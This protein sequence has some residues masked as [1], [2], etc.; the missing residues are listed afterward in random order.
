MARRI[1]HLEAHEFIPAVGERH[2]V[3]VSRSAQIEDDGRQ[4]IAEVYVLAPPEAVA[5]H[6]HSATKHGILRVQVDQR[7]ALLRGEHALD[8][9]CAPCIQITLDAPPIDRHEPHDR[10][11]CA[12]R[13]QRANCPAAAR[14]ERF[15]AELGYS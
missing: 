11:L 3:E 4:R 6:D 15:A 14:N 9:G 2:E 10:R 7:L 8:Q 1:A 12:T 13:K 5:A